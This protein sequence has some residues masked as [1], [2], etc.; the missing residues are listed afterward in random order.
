MHIPR[1]RN[2]AIALAVAGAFALGMNHDRL[3]GVPEAQAAPAAAITIPTTQAARALPDFSQLVDEQGPAVVFISVKKGA[4][5]TAQGGDG[6]QPFGDDELQEFF[7]RFGIPVP[8]QGRGTPGPGAERPAMGVGSG[9]VVSKDGFILTNA[10]VVE[11][12]SEVNVKLADKREFTAKVIGADKRSDVAVVKID[13]KDLPTVKIGD[14][15]RTRVGEW[16]AAIGAPFGLDNTVTS[17][18]VSAKSRSLPSDTLVPFIQ[19]DVAVNPGNSGGPLFNMAGEV[20]GINSQIYSR[21]G[22]YMGLSF[23]IPIDVAMNVKDQLVTHGKVTRG[24]I[25]VGVQPVTQA[26]AE[27]FGMKRADGALVSQ[28]EADGPAAKAGVKTGDVILSW[29]GKAIDGANSLPLAV[30][31]TKP[32]EQAKVEVWR[33]GAKRDLTV[34][35]G[36]MPADR[37][38]VAR[39]GDAQ[40]QGKLGVAV[41]ELAKEE[42]RKFGADGGLL[43]EQAQGPAARAGVQKGDVI[44]GVNGKP[45]KSVEELKAAVDAAGR[46]AAILVQRGEAR[47]FVPVQIG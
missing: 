12:A 19:T 26:L 25:G 36:E 10:H 28:V 41:R 17:G 45:V 22:G 8:P 34:T 29:N 30:A 5:R 2:T 7:R 47:I 3:S 46:N 18:I 9:F 24:R 37:G 31:G 40:P 32:G 21:T 11:G 39:A 16:V 38:Q 4:E 43:V 35:V 33:D 42:A 14:P 44:L 15:N 6:A 27:S 13:A 20:I 23:A 1:I